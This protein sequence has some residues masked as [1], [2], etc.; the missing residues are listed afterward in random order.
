MSAL[1]PV[2]VYYRALSP[3]KLG[4]FDEAKSLLDDMVRSAAESLASSDAALPVGMPRQSPQSREIAAHYAV[5]IARAGLGDTDRATAEFRQVLA[6]NPAHLGA[7][8]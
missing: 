3:Q 8:S 2:P 7:R 1:D 5:A 6:A 4:R